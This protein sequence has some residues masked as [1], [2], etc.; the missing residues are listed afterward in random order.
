VNY[1]CRQLG[2]TLYKSPMPLAFSAPGALDYQAGELASSS[3]VYFTMPDNMEQVSP[4]PS[5]ASPAE[6]YQQLP[7][8]QQEQEDGIRLLKPALGFK[9]APTTRNHLIRARKSKSRKAALQSMGAD[10]S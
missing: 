2:I 3:G 4:S 7:S 6:R 9:P 8:Q 5:S 10:G 1:Y